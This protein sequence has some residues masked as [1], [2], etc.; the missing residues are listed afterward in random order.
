MLVICIIKF[1][2]LNYTFDHAR[3][4]YLPPL[5]TTLYGIAGMVEFDILML[6]DAKASE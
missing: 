3:D 4:Y 1:K 5:S 2:N 6:N